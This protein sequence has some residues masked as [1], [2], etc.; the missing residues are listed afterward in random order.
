[1]IMAASRSFRCFL[2]RIKWNSSPPSQYLKTNQLSESELK[3][4]NHSL[5]LIQSDVST[6]KRRRNLL[7]NKEAYIVPFPDLMQLD[8]V[9]VVLYEK[10][11]DMLAWWIKMTRGTYE[12]FEDI[13]LVDK[14]GIVFDLF[15]LD[16][17]DS[18]LLVA[19]SMLSKVD[20]SEA[21][22]GQFLLKGVDLLDV[23]FCRIDEVLGLMRG[24]GGAGT[25]RA[26][27]FHACH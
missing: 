12:N 9:W 13:N 24:A 10:R 20:D 8:N 27:R 7:E 26:C 18:I 16:C 5:I 22:I 6:I 23:S 25:A 11:A 21:A 14:C 15:L 19:L 1:M 2:S 4:A 17:L 3:V